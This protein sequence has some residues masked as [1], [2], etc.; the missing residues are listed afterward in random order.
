MSRGKFILLHVDNE[1]SKALLED[2]IL[3]QGVERGVFFG[4][5][6]I[7]EL[8][9]QFSYMKERGYFPIGVVID[10][11]NSANNVEYLFKRHPNQSKEMKLIE[12]KTINPTEL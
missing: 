4:S 11:N 9:E 2:V 3:N 8:K 6:F 12:L 10:F 5:K 1:D 7:S